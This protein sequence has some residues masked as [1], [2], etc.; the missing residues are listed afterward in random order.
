MGL[1]GLDPEV[2]ELDLGLR[3][4]EG[5]GPFERGRLAVLVGEV[6]DLLARLGDDRGED[7]VDG[8]ARGEPDRGSAG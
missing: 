6:E 8:R 2:V 3:P 7:R 4:G 5:R 1:V